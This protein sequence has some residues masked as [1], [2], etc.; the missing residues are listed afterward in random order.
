MVFLANLD[1]RIVDAVDSLG[2]YLQRRGF[3]YIDLSV[4]VGASVFLISAMGLCMFMSNSLQ[5]TILLVLFACLVVWVAT[6]MWSK[7]MEAKKNWNMAQ[8]ARFSRSALNLRRVMQPVRIAFVC[9]YAAS[10]VLDIGVV[11]HYGMAGYWDVLG[12]LGLFASAAV[13]LLPM[14]FFQYAVCA[15]PVIPSSQNRNV[16]PFAGRRSGT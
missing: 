15:M 13:I 1:N 8:I 14:I 9:I 6:G 12:T 10:I 2:T 11:V 4:T 16:V 7:M 3:H 5:R